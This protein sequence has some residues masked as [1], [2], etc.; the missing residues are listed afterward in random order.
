MK[1]VIGAGILSLPL[2]VS[3]LGYVLALIVFAFVICIIQFTAVLLLKAK[4][5]S[6]HSNYSSISY[7]IFRTKVAQ[8]ICSLMILINNSG[9]CIIELT[10]LKGSLGR[11][12]DGY[13]KD[14]DIREAFYFSPYFIVI[15]C[16]VLE[17]PFTLVSKIEKLKFL[18]FMGV[19]GITVFVI[20]LIITFFA[21]MN[22]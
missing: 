9:I 18:A 2:T 15:V 11:I 4:N 13:I 1:T 3:R 21:E 20:T 12:F 8:T 7:H 10:I 19:S 16:A 6:K 22:E 17:C 14:P 5:L